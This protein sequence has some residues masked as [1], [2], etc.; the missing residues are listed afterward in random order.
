MWLIHLP[1]KKLF[2]VTSASSVLFS[3][4]KLVTIQRT[5]SSR[6]LTNKINDQNSGYME[7]EMSQN[8]FLGD[9]LL[10]SVITTTV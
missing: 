5:V 4:V 3:S 10:L 9:K 8:K 6:V 2:L 1:I 7:I